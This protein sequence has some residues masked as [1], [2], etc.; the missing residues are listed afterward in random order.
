LHDAQ[1]AE[2]TALAE[3]LIN[4]PAVPEE[5]AALFQSIREKNQETLGPLFDL[6]S[7]ANDRV[8]D[9]AGGF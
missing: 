4:T 2:F 6:L 3:E 9:I 8:R 7:T 5:C 1:P